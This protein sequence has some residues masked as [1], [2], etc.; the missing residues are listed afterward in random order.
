M[1]KIILPALLLIISATSCIEN[2]LAL[3]E[4][5]R[6]GKLSLSSLLTKSGSQDMPIDTFALKSYLQSDPGLILMRQV[7][8][9]DNKFFLSISMDDALSIGITPEMYDQCCRYVEELNRLGK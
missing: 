7:R 8:V 1:K 9:K 5:V 4:E 6:N 3:P 2:N